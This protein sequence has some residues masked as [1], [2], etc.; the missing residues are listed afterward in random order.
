MRKATTFKA[1]NGNDE[2]AYLI[3]KQRAKHRDFVIFKREGIQNMLDPNLGVNDLRVLIWMSLQ[4]E[5]GTDYIIACSQLIIAQALNI[6]QSAV[7]NALRSLFLLKI[8]RKDR[9]DNGFAIWVAN[10]RFMTRK[11]NN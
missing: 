5:P 9:L 7:S 6:S 3:V 4:I 1:T 10:N 11:R 2:V 8:I